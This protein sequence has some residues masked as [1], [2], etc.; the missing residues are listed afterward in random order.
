MLLPT[1]QLRSAQLTHYRQVSQNDNERTEP[2]CLDNGMLQP[3]QSKPAQRVALCQQGPTAMASAETAW[4]YHWGLPL[5]NDSP[6]QL[7]STMPENLQQQC[8]PTMIV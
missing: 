2:N 7:T 3:S 6:A 1:A 4:P 5:L 8:R